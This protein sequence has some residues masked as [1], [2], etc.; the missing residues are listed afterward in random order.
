MNEFFLIMP[1]IM[2]ILTL[3]FVVF[4][5]IFYSG[6]DRRLIGPT[7][8]MGLAGAFLQTILTYQYG[9]AQ[10]FSHTFSVDGLSLFF[11]LLFIGL[12][13]LSM[14]TASP[15]RELVSE[16][17]TEFIA[18]VLASTLAMCL[19]ASAT[20]L[21]LAFLALQCVNILAY[22]IAGH[23]KNS[24]FSIEAAVKYM[25][26]SSV[27]GAFLLYGIA[28]LFSAT[29]TLNIYEMHRY[30][31]ANPLTRESNLIVFMMIFLSLC[32]Q[33]AAFPMHFWAP[34]VIDGA[35]TPVA[36]FLSVGTRATGL[37]VALRVLIGVFA[38]SD[39]VPGQWQVL[40]SI[41]WTRIV[42]VV[43]ALTMI[44][45]ALLAYRQQ[46]AKR[47]VGCLIMSESGFLLLGL[48]V[49]DQ[50][51]VAALLYSLVIE[52]FSIVGI[53]YILSYF[54]DEVGS[55]RFSDLNGM[56][57]RAVPECMGLVFFLI[58]LVGIP[59]AP[60]FIG[61][62]ALIGSAIRHHWLLL[63]V[64]AIFS[65]TLS[66]IAVARFAYGLSGD[67]RFTLSSPLAAS[68]KRRMILTIL[69]V[70]I[71]VAGIWAE[72]LLDWAGKSLNFIF[73]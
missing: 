57:G 31:L 27:S 28:L 29:Q 12:A 23:G 8:L 45:G 19:A 65:I 64:I 71:A 6:E 48:L 59:P 47:M 9:A 61:K 72:G 49:L 22:F 18:L 35:P 32:F 73:W 63:G 56:M 38:Q 41:D 51:G 67:L 66:T 15:G 34:D 14:V 1:E 52:L 55:D 26:F 40:G 4:G 3:A 62:F 53:F 36:S 16:R 44:I 11:K 54:F 25:I 7:A 39:L 50:V 68:R 13:A 30:L 37:A 70:P 10:I 5:E 60:G 2:V 42:A 17:R 20:D 21:L 46:A 43:A 24:I 58:S 69:L 33:F